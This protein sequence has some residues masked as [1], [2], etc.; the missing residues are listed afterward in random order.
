MQ[1]SSTTINT[2]TT[3]SADD[4]GKYTMIEITTPI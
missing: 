4:A 1:G 3:L 2:Y